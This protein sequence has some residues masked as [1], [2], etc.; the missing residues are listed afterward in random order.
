MIKL[1]KKIFEDWKIFEL[2]L[3][4][5]GLAVVIT[6]GIIFKTDWLTFTCSILGI[7]TVLLLAKGKI[8]GQFLGIIIVILY[9]IVSFREAYYGELSHIIFMLPIYVYGIISWM[10]NKDKEKNTIKINEIKWKEWIVLFFVSLTSFFGFYYLL[11][12]F[13]TNALIISTISVLA[14]MI[15]VYLLARRSKYGFVAYIIDDIALII[16]WG[17]PVFTNVGG[18]G[19]YLIPMLIYSVI[20]AVNHVYGTLNWHMIKKNQK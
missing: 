9:S 6:T 15:G 13:N 19:Y 4:F 14:S 2:S 3:L 7:I 18:A 11:K 16:L 10:K 17:I 12:F 5:F 20:N 8:L 1:W